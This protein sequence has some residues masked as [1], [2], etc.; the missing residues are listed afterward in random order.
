M[1]LLSMLFLLSAVYMTTSAFA[2][3]FGARR[4]AATRLFGETSNKDSS[5]GFYDELKRRIVEETS[6]PYADLFHGAT[7]KH[8]YP[9][10][11]HIVSFQ[12]GTENQ[13]IHSIEYPKNSGNNVILAFESKAACDKF[14]DDLRAQHFFDPTVREATTLCCIVNSRRS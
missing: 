6:N 2:P 13:G 12:P 9:G 1:I 10:T 3:S 4:P 8:A 14:A 7:V 5:S 11:V